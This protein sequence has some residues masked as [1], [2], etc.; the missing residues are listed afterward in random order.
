MAE[1]ILTRTG[2]SLPRMNE[3]LADKFDKAGG[4]V[5][6]PVRISDET[7]SV[8]ETTGALVIDGGLGVAGD[9]HANIVYGGAWNDYAERRVT[10]EPDAYQAKPGQVLCETGEGTLALSTQRM[11]PCPWVYSDT[12]GMEIGRRDKYAL[13]VAVSG[14]A[15]VHVEGDRD[16]Y[17][18]GDVLCAAPGGLACKMT[19]EEA[20]AYPDRALGVVLSV[21]QEEIWGEKTQVDGRVWIRV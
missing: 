9:I 15:L 11:Q 17:Q 14:R 6:G 8:D 16:S 10:V 2:V 1:A 20:S 21:P 19:R 5:T 18:A 7:E 4:E 12:Y 3:E 13:P